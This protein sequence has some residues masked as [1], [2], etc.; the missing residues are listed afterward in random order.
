MLQPPCGNYYFF[1]GEKVGKKSVVVVFFVFLAVG[2]QFRPFETLRFTVTF[3]TVPIP[4]LTSPCN[5]HFGQVLYICISLFFVNLFWSFFFF[6]S[7]CFF[8]SLFF[9]VSFCSVI[10]RRMDDS[11]NNNNKIPS[12]K[13]QK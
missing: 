12:W 10:M 13:Y 7:F 6:L 11:S 9:L 2:C 8:I 4:S 5:S 1:G 3:Q